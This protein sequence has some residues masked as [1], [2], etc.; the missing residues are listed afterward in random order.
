MALTG[1]TIN[2]PSTSVSNESGSMYSENIEKSDI[3]EEN[4]ISEPIQ[5][6]PNQKVLKESAP[7]PIIFN[8]YGDGY[9]L[10]VIDPTGIEAMNPETDINRE[11]NLIVNK[12]MYAMSTHF[13]E[14]NV[15][16]Y[17]PKMIGVYNR[18]GGD[19]TDP[20]YPRNRYFTINYEVPATVQNEPM[21]ITLTISL[22]TEKNDGKFLYSSLDGYQVTIQC[23]GFQYICA[24][25]QTMQ[26]Y[27]E[28]SG[29]FVKWFDM[30]NFTEID[31][32]EGTIVEPVTNNESPNTGGENGW[33]ST[34]NNSWNVLKALG[35][36]NFDSRFGWHCFL[37]G[38]RLYWI[39]FMGYG[40]WR[41]NLRIDNAHTITL[42]TEDGTTW[43]SLTNSWGYR[44][45][46]WV[47][48]KNGFMQ[49]E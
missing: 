11:I 46:K 28:T 1:C 36:T 45:S 21:G 38:Y 22:S 7:T 23:D 20:D 25:N 5:E 29:E 8:Q 18:D 34:A 31:I 40:T 41:Y 6:K 42:A 12:M 4:E 19:P 33:P 14:E 35:A 47:L 49:I 30:V 43:E 24:D 32:P 15:I 44:D 10:D 2:S 27:S 13:W 17:E 9:T 3:L 26:I 37:Y 48:T 16:V 39:D